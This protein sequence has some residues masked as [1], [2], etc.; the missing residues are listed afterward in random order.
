MII[1]GNSIAGLRQKLLERLLMNN[2]L[3]QMTGQG[4]GNT[5]NIGGGSLTSPSLGSGLNAGLMT[6]GGLTTTGGLGSPSLSLL[7]SGGLLGRGTQTP[8]L[9]VASLLDSMSAPRAQISQP[10]KVLTRT[11]AI[12]SLQRRLDALRGNTL[13]ETQGVLKSGIGFQT[14]TRDQGLKENIIRQTRTETPNA[15]V[16][17]TVKRT[18]KTS[19]AGK[20]SKANTP[21]ILPAATDS[22]SAASLLNNIPRAPSIFQSAPVAPVQQVTLP[23]IQTPPAALV[24]KTLPTKATQTANLAAAA[25]A[26][27]AS[28]AG[29]ASAINSVSSVAAAKS[30]QNQISDMMDTRMDMIGDMAEAGMLGGGMMGLGGLSAMN[31]LGGLGGLGS[32][33]GLGGSMGSMGAMGMGDMM[34]S[35][36]GMGMA[37][38]GMGG[39]GMGNSLMGGGLGGLMGGG[40]GGLGMM[41][42][43][44]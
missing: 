3:Q 17:I 38:L 36:G 35:L 7:D 19:G 21:S 10:T 1:S 14:P 15:S 24:Q 18:T 32:M 20:A 16:K 30:M 13:P 37:G 29:A 2:Q 43:F 34:G 8:S 42:A 28:A 25:A 33:G 26:S 44:S 12:Q 4:L 40:L 41:A 39:L 6:G 22:F 23:K 5:M 27:A 9:N 31:S 11:A